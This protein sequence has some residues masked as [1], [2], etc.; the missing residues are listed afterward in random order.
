MRTGAALTLVLAFLLARLASAVPERLVSGR[1]RMDNDALSLL[2]DLSGRVM[3]RS[4]PTLPVSA[5]RPTGIVKEPSYR[6]TPWYG[7]VRVGNGPRAETVF[8]MDYSPNERRV[9]NRLYFDHNHN[10]DLTDEGDGVMQ[11]VGKS[12]PGA[13]VGPHF[14]V[15]PASWMIEG[16]EVVDRYGMMFLFGADRSGEGLS[17]LSRTAAVRRGTIEVEGR[18]LQLALIESGAQ[19]NFEIAS[20]AP[21]TR[22]NFPDRSVRTMTLLLDAD[23]DGTFGPQEVFDAC[24]PVQLGAVTYVAGTPVDGSHLTLTPTD[25]S[26]QVVNVPVRRTVDERHLLPPGTAAP[27]FV[28]KD[29]DGRDVSLS[30]FRGRIVVLDFWA[31][32]CIPCI[33]SMPHVQ[34][35]I[36]Q[37]AGGKDIVW[38]GVCVWDDVA[39]FKRWVPLNDAKY[40]FIK[41]VDPAGKDRAT[42]IA[43]HL[44]RATGIPTLYVIDRGGRIVAGMTGYL[45]D[46]DDRLAHALRRAGGD[47]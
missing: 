9:E 4:G 47:R 23:G 36:A 37:A 32:W 17:M 44:Y 20:A 38:L 42:S 19:G 1:L 10:G 30:D 14:E 41:V 26:A 25:R 15:L 5:T 11:S 35:T 40:S 27:D 24:L 33:R 6:G 13:R 31:T 39:S 3:P 12:L 2:G 45:G 16:R 34:K 28:A 7:K 21:A 8:V 22:E 29:R 43:G 18:H 46:D